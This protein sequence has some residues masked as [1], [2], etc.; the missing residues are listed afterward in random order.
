MHPQFLM[1]HCVID[2]KFMKTSGSDV[3][4]I[5]PSVFG[6][7]ITDR[8]SAGE[9]REFLSSIGDL[10]GL[11]EPA[12]RARIRTASNKLKRKSSYRNVRRL[13]GSDNV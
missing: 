12:Q 8:V 10:A 13:R 1:N 2:P 3:P 9:L 7:R 4:V 11:D 6:L 5:M